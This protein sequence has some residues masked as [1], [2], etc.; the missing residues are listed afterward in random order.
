MRAGRRG[1]SRSTRRHACARRRVGAAALGEPR[2]TVIVAL[3]RARA[4]SGSPAAPARG[5]R[6]GVVR[7]GSPPASSLTIV[8]VEHR[9]SPS[10]AYAAPEASRFAAD[11]QPQQRHAA[12]DS[13]DRV[14]TGKVAKPMPGARAH[15]GAPR[16]RAERGV[17]GDDRTIDAE[18][19]AAAVDGLKVSG[20]RRPR[21]LAGAPTYAAAARARR[22]QPGART[23]AGA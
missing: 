14:Q 9:S 6:V 11:H 13:S 3:A 16:R 7:R 5:P 4:I 1:R 19:E 18:A 8:R 17:G 21:T 15:L 20:R 10:R 2:F 23:G 22:T 12:R